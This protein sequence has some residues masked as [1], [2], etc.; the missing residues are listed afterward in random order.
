MKTKD[1]VIIQFCM[2]PKINLPY[3]DWSLFSP[4]KLELNVDETHYNYVRVKKNQK[5][6]KVKNK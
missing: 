2:S 5:M 6:C 1:N 3:L 4:Y